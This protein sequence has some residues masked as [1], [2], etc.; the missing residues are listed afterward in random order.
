[1]EK[2]K[3]PAIRHIG[4]IL[5]GN[6]RWAK[7]RKLLSW[8]GHEAGVEKVIDLIKWALDL[9]IRELTLYTFSIQ[10]FKREAPEVEFLMNLFRNN[11]DRLLKDEKIKDKVKVNFIGRNWL[12]EQDIQEKQQELMEKT[13]KNSELIVNLAMGYG[14]REEIID[15]VKKIG[16]ELLEGRINLREINE[17]TF[18]QYLHLSSSP[19]IIIRT[20]GEK[21][22]SNF[23]LWQS[24]YSEFFFLDK[25]WPDFEREDLEKVME[26]FRNR[27]RR[28]GG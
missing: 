15:A 5:D 9:K 8:K 14:G 21:R 17:D 3:E 22:I 11:F 18:N 2:S 25:F 24:H 20:G 19:E 26:E 27:E 23:L 10:N 28:F 12:F 4:V 7:E 16:G 13:R 1:M 6:R